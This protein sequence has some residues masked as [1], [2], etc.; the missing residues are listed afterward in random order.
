[1]SLAHGQPTRCDVSS[2][3][4]ELRGRTMNQYLA[5]A[6]AARLA[7]RHPGARLLLSHDYTPNHPTI[8][9]SLELLTLSCPAQKARTVFP[10]T[11]H[12]QTD[13]NTHLELKVLCCFTIIIRNNK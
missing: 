7:V 2:P 8:H 3:N 13:R 9:P 1:M 6:V 12:E 11:P 10:S 5:Q 4:Y